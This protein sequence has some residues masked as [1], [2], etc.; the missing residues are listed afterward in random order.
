MKKFYLLLVLG[1]ALTAC[2]SS[3]A[4]KDRQFKD[5]IARADGDKVL[6]N[7]RFGISKE[8]FEVQQEQFLEEH[9]DS[10]YGYYIQEI[11]GAF[12]PA[13]Q[14]YQV[15]FVGVEFMKY[16][17]K[18][19]PFRDFLTEK[20]GMATRY[21]P[22]KWVVGDRVISLGQERRNRSIHYALAVAY[23]TLRDSPNAKIEPYY[24][25]FFD[26]YLMT[27]VS[28]S[29]SRENQR[30]IDEMKKKKADEENE[31]MRQKQMSIEKQQAEDLKTL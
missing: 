17:E 6:G 22:N 30:Q 9:N 23:Q 26:F 1:A 18:E 14:L 24:K 15:K 21:K 10:I 20:F 11:E 29:L 12:T 28:D 19:W 7:I 3:S 16:P 4:E 31:E 27:F 8:E 2:Q 25:E 5:S 13:D